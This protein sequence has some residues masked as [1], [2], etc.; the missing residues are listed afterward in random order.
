[1]RHERGRS[2]RPWMG[3]LVVCLLGC[4]QRENAAVGPAVSS[5]VPVEL[6]SDQ[7]ITVEQEIIETGPRISGSL[8]PS[9]K[10][11]LRAEVSGLV[12]LLAVEHGDLVSAGQLLARIEDKGQRDA[13]TS[14]RAALTAAKDDEDVAIRQAARARRLVAA[15]AIAGVEAESAEAAVAAAT[16]RTVA[17]R[18]QL[19]SSRKQLLGREVRAPFDGVVDVQDV[20]QGDVVSLGAPLLTILDPTSLRLEAQVASDEIGRVRVGQDVRV[21]VR[22]GSKQALSGTIER[23]AP[24]VDSATRQLSVSVTL[25]ERSDQLVA[26]LFAD[27]RILVDVRRALVVPV[28]ALLDDSAVPTVLRVREGRTERVAIEP[29]LQDEETDRIEVRAGLAAGDLVVVGPARRMPAGARVVVPT[30]LATVGTSG[31]P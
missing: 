14:A 28:D 31:S 17:A 2:L 1:M 11:L 26:G 16:A 9:R 21:H 15:G 27:G 7:L 24:S 5:E 12:T 25:H 6:A 19:A 3:V 13:A 20:H 8:R 22:G 18:A 29:G 23:I 10:A 4:G 30:T